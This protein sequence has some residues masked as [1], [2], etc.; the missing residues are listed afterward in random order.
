IP[1]ACSPTDLQR[2][3][4]ATSLK[5]VEPAMSQVFLCYAPED[6]GWSQSV[7]QALQ[8][9]GWTVWMPHDPH[10]GQDGVRMIRQGIERTDN[11]IYLLS[12]SALTSDQ[13][14]IALDDA[15]RYHKRVIVVQQHG[16]DVDH[17]AESLQTMPRI[18]WSGKN[19][20]EAIA[21]L[22]QTLQQ[23]ADY[24][25][26]HKILL[27]KALNW[28]RHQQ[29]EDELLLGKDFVDAEA[30]LETGKLTQPDALPTRL[31][32]KFI[33]ASQAKNRFFDGFISY[34]RPDSLEFATRLHEALGAAGFNIWFDKMD[35]PPG[36]DFQA[37]IDDG[38]ERSHNFIFLISPHSTQSVYC[39]KE[40]ELA[41]KLNKRIIPLMHVEQ[42]TVETWQKRHPAAPLA[43]WETYKADG[44]HSSYNHIHP[45]IGKINWIF[46][47][48]G[49]D[50]FDQSLNS[51]TALL[52]QHERYVQMHTD[53]LIKSLDWKRHQFANQ[54]LLVGESRR[55]A[56]L[57]LQLEFKDEQAPCLPTDLQCE[58]IAESRKYAS[59]SCTQVFLCGAAGD[60]VEG[61]ITAQ[62]L[63]QQSLSIK[64]GNDTEDHGTQPIVSSEILQIR[65]LLLRA[66]FTVWSYATDIRSGDQM[67]EAIKRGIEGADNFVFLL[68]DAS[69]ESKRCLQE[70]DYAL[71]LNKRIIPVMLTPM[72]VSDLPAPLQKL[73][74]INFTPFL[75]LKQIGASGSLSTVVETLQKLGARALADTG[76]SG[77]GSRPLR[78]SVR[79]LLKA[80]RENDT[81]YRIHKQLLTI[82]LKWDRQRRNPALLFRGKTLKQYKSWMKLACQ[83]L[84]HPPTA[85]QMEFM[86]TSEEQSPNPTLDV[87]I[88]HA[89]EDF[90]FARKLNDTLQIQGQTTWFEDSSLIS[91]TD[92][93]VGDRDDQ[94]Q[95]YPS[96]QGTLQ[97]INQAI[98]QST[99]FLFIASP[100]SLHSASCL[101]QLNYANQLNKRIV[102][103]LHLEVLGQTHPVLSQSTWIDFS[104][105]ERDFLSVFGDLYRILASDPEHIHPHTRLL[106]KAKEWEQSA[107]DDSFLLRGQDLATAIAWLEQAEDKT[108]PPTDLQR[109]Y[110]KV[111]Q[112]RPLRK[113]EVGPVLRTSGVFAFIVFLLNIFVD[114]PLT[115]NLY[116]AMLRSRPSEPLD[117]RILLVTVNE[118]AGSWL[119]E[120]LKAKRYQPSIG[121]IPDAALSDALDVLLAYQPRVIGLDFYRDFEAEPALAEHLRQSENLIGLCKADVD[122]QGVSPPP[123]LPLERVGLNDLLDDGSQSIR[124]QY[125]MQSPDPVFCNTRE[126]FSLKLAQRYLEGE[127][128]RFESPLY[129]GADGLIR[130][131]TN[132]M[133]VGTVTVP[134]LRL[135]RGPGSRDPAN[136]RGYQT[137]LNFRTYQGKVRKFAP[138]VTLAEVLTGQVQ[139]EQVRD[140][141]VVILYTDTTDRNA[142]IWNTP[143]GEV[144]GGVLQAQ[145]VSQLVSAALDNRPLLRWWPVWGEGLW[146]LLWAIAGG[147][148]LWPFQSFRNVVGMAIAALLILYGT[149]SLILIGAALWVPIVPAAIALIL[150]GS[151]VV[152]LNH[153][154]RNG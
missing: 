17:L 145:M 67:E 61:D 152:Y 35:I 115:L 93:L 139:P 69:L 137:L 1:Y 25:A 19:G 109:D 138:Q 33:A 81:Y 30:W 105:P 13:C 50:S 101:E 24:Y 127:G 73:Q 15:Q 110:I 151:R 123:E 27:V 32:E 79:Q 124:R 40:I 42:I 49:I 12:P 76:I 153:R 2:E 74:P 92:E 140:R 90:E 57:W 149:C 134:Q 48:E 141:V 107:R 88:A 142:D 72:P 28:E 20:G 59:N 4:I 80:L 103:V 113:I 89:P 102:P 91:A 95:S 23:Q 29:S 38:I 128:I 75:S 97:E 150:T 52:H 8:Q 22:T 47:R 54:Y 70:L 94:T 130:Y 154:L 82:A 133:K 6:E 41:V 96:D 71:S 9:A 11:V 132:G 31:H 46:F 7:R 84:Q 86:A 53:L 104:R 66:G 131:R 39:R 120:Q 136:L 64:T 87:F 44:R 143:Y 98:E 78:Q 43:E 10:P 45:E 85:L 100:A 36:V 37:Q 3:F 56:K 62:S 148:A 14:Q 146:I 114:W 117:E 126:S 119:R 108:P 77:D 18:A 116:D 135:G 60:R 118:D 5:Q 144:P 21:Q 83:N 34:G 111:S 129:E 63:M 58:L 65:R 51:L 68:T 122:G 147:F 121:T 112:E 125:L 16:T 26:Y 99:N 55:K 106:V